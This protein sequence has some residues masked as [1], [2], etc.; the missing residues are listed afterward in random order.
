MPFRSILAII[1]LTIAT[2]GFAQTLLEGRLLRF[3]D[4]SKDKIAFSYGGDL[5]LVSREGG[6]AQRI[7][8]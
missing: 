7:T 4:V 3:P 2:S 1:L 5:W 8:S 6:T